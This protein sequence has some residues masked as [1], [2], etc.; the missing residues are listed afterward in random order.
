[1]GSHVYGYRI[2]AY[3]FALL[4]NITVHYFILGHLVWDYLCLHT[5]GR[6]RVLSQALSG[7]TVEPLSL[8]DELA[9]CRDWPP[10]CPHPRTHKTQTTYPSEITTS[11]E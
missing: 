5:E 11:P 9:C 4:W 3:L 10:H 8:A 7:W 1:M 6:G 2:S